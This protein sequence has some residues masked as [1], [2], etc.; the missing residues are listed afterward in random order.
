V[1]K[2]EKRL[3]TG[4]EKTA[5]GISYAGKKPAGDYAS[6][7]QQRTAGLTEKFKESSLKRGKKKGQRGDSPKPWSTQAKITRTVGG[8]LFSTGV[9]AKK[10]APIKKLDGGWVTGRYKKKDWG[11]KTSGHMKKEFT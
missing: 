6:G 5:R 7:G 2:K 3:S 4:K 8:L 10:R 9:G 11:A 1:K